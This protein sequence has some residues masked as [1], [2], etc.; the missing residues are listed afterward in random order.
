MKKL[1]G[2]LMLA[3]FSAPSWAQ[4]FDKCQV[5]VNAMFMD[6]N[7]GMDPDG[8]S[9]VVGP[10]GK[11][12]PNK[13]E[14]IVNRREE[15]GVESLAYVGKVPYFGPNGMEFKEVA[16]VVQVR[17]D[18]NNRILE[19]TKNFDLR[20]VVAGVPGAPLYR[21]HNHK[22]VY[23]DKGECDLEQSF[24]IAVNDSED[25]GG[26]KLVTF[27]KKLCDEISPLMK[28][29][30]VQNA[31]QCGN[32]ML[33]ASNLMQKRNTELQAEKKTLMAGNGASMNELNA[34]SIIGA[35]AMKDMVASNLNYG[36]AAPGGYGGGQSPTPAAS[37]RG[38]FLKKTSGRPVQ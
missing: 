28:Q 10:D 6:Q 31:A 19:V 32:L 37:A 38:S 23:G 18:R 27:D 2:I 25:K 14:R 30:G 29:M 21:A 4:T 12:Y 34:G 35:C 11:I 3:A 15:N 22:M 26:V 1:F 20:G 9:L 5:V 36:M 13:P 7:M 16:Q 8:V 33:Q 17:R 24:V